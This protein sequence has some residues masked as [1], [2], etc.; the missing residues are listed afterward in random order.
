MMNYTDSESLQAKYDQERDKRLRPEGYAQYFNLHRDLPKLEDD[1]WIDYDALNAQKPALTDGDEIRFLIY[2]AGHVGLLFAGRLVEAGVDPKDICLVDIAG[3]YGGTW[4]YNRYPGLTCDVEGYIYLP[5]LE[6]TGYVPKHRYSTGEEIRTH[7]ER[8][9]KHF[10]LHALFAT[11]VK[12]QTWDEARRRWMVKMTRNLGPGLGK[13]DLE[14]QAQFTYSASG[15]FTGPKAPRIPGLDSFKKPM[16]HTARWD[17][18]Y[19]GGSPSD[20]S[21]VKL[22]DKT[23]G[24]I[25]TGATS[26][27]IVPE[28]AKWAKKLYVFQRTPSAVG[29]R[30]QIETSPEQW[31]KVASGKGWQVKRQLNFE[32]YLAGNHEEEDMIKDGWSQLGSLSGL[33][34]GETYITPAEVAEYQRMMF[35]HDRVVADGK[36]AFVDEIVKDSAT[37]D[38]LKAWYPSYCKRPV[39]HNEYLPTFN[40][41]NVTLVDTN[42]N[43]VDRFSE[44]SVIVDGREYGVDV[45]ILATGFDLATGAKAAPSI[46]SNISTVGRNGRDLEEKWGA[47]D[48]GAFHGVLTH[49]FPNMLFAGMN[50]AIGSLN[51]TATYDFV[52]KHAANIAVLALRKASDPNK[53]VIEVSKASE[54]AWTTDTLHRA[55]RFSVL[56]GCT[57]GYFNHEGATLLPK[58][59]EQKVLD[60]KRA[61]WAGG[62]LNYK[63]IVDEYDAKGNLEG[64]DLSE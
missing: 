46:R 53:A 56:L 15:L 54:D 27:Q 38:K 24:I 3:G 52:G 37:A 57:P 23:V 60:G 58:S 40:R 47:A 55:M 31:S 30:D 44:D 18:K 49:E 14:V 19:T 21:L 12:S 5:F 63:R 1:I 13:V 39:F 6:E 35:D 34:G 51:L 25:G 62:V 20:P 16:F 17:Y 22:T 43:G 41:P 7:A 29:T 33:V 11:T 10:N 26:V 36:R 32:K 61:V 48:F 28:V 64:I 9:A 8:V 4:Y 50:G 59:M 45:L 42:G 2:G